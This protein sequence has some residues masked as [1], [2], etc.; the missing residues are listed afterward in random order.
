MIDTS[1]RDKTLILLKEK[2]VTHKLTEIA[3]DTELPIGW[4]KSFAQRGEE[5]DSLSDRIYTLY[6]HLSGRTIEF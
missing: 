4:L 5:Y 1:L 2:R 6:K 3:K